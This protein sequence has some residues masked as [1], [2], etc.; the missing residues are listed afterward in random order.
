M[1]LQKRLHKAQQCKPYRHLAPYNIIAFQTMDQTKINDVIKSLC[2]KYKDD[3]FMCVKTESFICQQLPIILQNIK[4]NH[5]EQVQRINELN[6]E[7]DTFIQG[8]LASNRYFYASTTENFFY[9]DGTNYSNVTEDEIL[10][11]VLSAISRDRTLMTWKYKTKSAIMKQIK[12]NAIFSCIP[13]SVTIQSVLNS[14]YPAI[15]ATKAEAKY[16]LTILGENMMKKQGNEMLI[17]IISP[18]AK[19]FINGLNAISQMWFGINL[20]QTFKYKYHADHTYSQMR[21]LHSSANV[22]NATT[23]AFNLNGINLLCVACH[24]SNRYHSSDN[25]LVKYSNDIGLTDSAFFLKNATSESLAAMFLNEYIISSGS[26]NSS[27]SLVQVSWKNMMYLWKH[28]LESKKLPSVMAQTKLKNTLI[29]M[30]DHNYLADSDCF[31][32][33]SSKYLPTVNKFLQFWEETMVY[34]ETEPEIE[35]SEVATLFRQNTGGGIG[36]TQIVN[37][38]THFFPDLEIDQGKYIYR[39]RSTMWDKQ[40]DIMMAMDDLRDKTG[41]ESFASVSVYDSYAHYCDYMSGGNRTTNGCSSEV[42]KETKNPSLPSEVSRRRPSNGSLATPLLVS[43]QYFE[44]YMVL[45]TK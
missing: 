41:A 23:N 24:Y 25:Y 42:S 8:F 10:H 21:I 3:T 11:K 43:K 36:E 26:S 32:G 14:L 20:N 44:K 12:E 35:I 19:T 2:E 4:K 31:V 6:V 40:V 13:E 18:V 38:L 27:N 17:H 22:A 1:R 9:Y 30:L 28:F 34:D 45:S 16:F 33:I 37:I 39:M 15:F 5:V 29:A 7:Q